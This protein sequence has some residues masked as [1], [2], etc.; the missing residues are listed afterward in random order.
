MTFSDVCL[1]ACFVGFALSSLRWLRV[2]QREHYL[3]WTTTRFAI[4]WWKLGA[5]NLFA[6]TMAFAAVI[7]SVWF[8]AGAILT[9]VLAAFGPFGL[10][11]KGRTSSLAW[12]RRL[13]T[14]SALHLLLSL[15]VLTTLRVIDIG[16]FGYALLSL[17]APILVDLAL[18][19]LRPI[20]QRAAN[21]YVLQATTTLERIDPVRVAVT[22]S[23]G[24]TTIKGYIRHLL[25]DN[26]SVVASPASFNNSAGLS[27]AVNEHLT[28][29]TEVFIAEMGTYG[30]G[31]IAD[32]VKWVQPSISVLASIGPVHLERF[33]DLDTIVSSKSEIFSSSR[34]AIVNIDA[35]GLDTEA[36]RLQASGITVLKCS[37][38]NAAANIFVTA[39]TG[40]SISI[41]GREIARNLK[42]DAVP[43]NVACAIAVAVSLGVAE[44]RIVERVGALPVP[45]HRRQLLTSPSGIEIIDDTYNSNPAGVAVALSTLSQLQAQRKAVVTPGMVEL[46][47]RQSA[48]NRRLGV[49]ASL[50]ADDFVIVGKT[51]RAALTNG[52]RDGTARVHFVAN[53]QEATE[54]VRKN[55]TQGDAVLYEN[56][57]PDHYP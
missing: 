32:L 19:I 23:Y 47:S 53:R 56:D 3:P 45:E 14:L 44:E 36:N 8:A 37:S 13:Q 29:G 39:D 55:L 38:E 50:I 21:R 15:T 43:I 42:S 2:A 22:G 9:A 33:G 7:S 51:N 6:L 12:T 5:V 20:E 10:G 26:Y 1:I 11:L 30:P 24:K 25:S 46:G 40:L 48:E 49:D 18:A 28:E 57:L 52:A 27:R 4:R 34:I 35:Y 54:W 17:A 41:D 16:A 31:E